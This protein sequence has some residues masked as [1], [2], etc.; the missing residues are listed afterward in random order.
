MVDQLN[1]AYRLFV[2]NTLQYRDES[3]MFTDRNGVKY[4]R[5]WRKDN[6]SSIQKQLA[7]EKYLSIFSYLFGFRPYILGERPT[8]Y[9]TFDVL[10]EGV[11]QRLNVMPELHDNSYITLD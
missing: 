10:S 3:S 7:K 4:C 1:A 6:Y 9:Y 11:T 2:E 5:Y 8:P